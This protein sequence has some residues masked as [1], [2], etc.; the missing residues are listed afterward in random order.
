[1]RWRDV[2]LVTCDHSLDKGI[3]AQMRRKELQCMQPHRLVS[4]HLP[5]RSIRR[6]SQCLEKGSTKFLHLRICK[7]RFR[8]LLQGMGNN[9]TIRSHA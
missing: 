1:M 8:A 5:Y 4:A 3:I 9:A 7:K 6:D 2:V